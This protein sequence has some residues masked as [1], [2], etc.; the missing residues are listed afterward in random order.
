[1]RGGRTIPLKSITDE[2]LINCPNVKKCVVVKRTG[3]RINWDECRVVWFEDIIK[4]VS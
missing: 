2:A 4:K 1:M 3:N